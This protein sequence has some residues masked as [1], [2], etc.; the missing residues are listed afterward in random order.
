M[1][2]LEAPAIRRTMPIEV[3][4]MT[5]EENAQKRKEKQFVTSPDDAKLADA[6]KKLNDQVDRISRETRRVEEEQVARNNGET[7]NRQRQIS[8]PREAQ[9]SQTQVDRH[10][11][12]IPKPNEDGIPV[13]A[14]GID[15][16]MGGRAAERVQ[17]SDSTIAEY[18]PEVKE[19]GFTSLN[20]DQFIHYTFYARINEQI[21]NRWVQHL[22]TFANN[23]GP[24]VLNKLS[25]ND[26][27]TE[28]EVLLDK[29][30]NFHDVIFHRKAGH[31]DL[32]IAAGGAIEVAAP[33]LNPPVEMIKE[34]GYIHLYYSFYVHWRS[35]YYARP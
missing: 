23:A 6:V 17:L 15:R 21:R 35:S 30:G 4:Y 34:D 33:F 29:N 27:I 32:D 8:R 31:P 13:V 20:T 18:I 11:N 9:Q 3:R 12:T 28:L 1:L 2:R 5:D 22:R 26:Q 10:Q 19:G 24:T 14:A 7:R 25:Q 16:P